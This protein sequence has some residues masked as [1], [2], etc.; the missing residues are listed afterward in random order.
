MLYGNGRN[1][2]FKG[3]RR[4]ERPSVR[5][6]CDHGLDAELYRREQCGDVQAH[7]SGDSACNPSPPRGRRRDRGKEA[8]E[9]IADKGAHGGD[10]KT[11]GADGRDAPV[12]EEQRLDD[13]RRGNGDHRRPGAYEHGNERCAHG[14]AGRAADNGDVEH[15]DD[16]AEG[17]AERE[18]RDLLHLERLVQLPR[19]RCPERHHDGVHRPVSCRAQIS[20]RDVHRPTPF[21]CI[22]SRRSLPSKDSAGGVFV[23][24]FGCG[25]QVAL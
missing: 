24:D 1:R 19:R 12:S 3:E 10:V 16:E 5:R 13:E 4:V 6:L 23:A 7:V 21:Y 18:I 17:R 20:V 14:M 11:V 15:H 22:S 8:I 9:S 25:L 2:D